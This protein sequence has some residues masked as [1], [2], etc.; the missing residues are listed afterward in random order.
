VSL[1]G[2]ARAA[3]RLARTAASA[4]ILVPGVHP[5]LTQAAPESASYARH[6]ASCHAADLSGSQFGPALKGPTFEAH[7]RNRDAADFS[8]Y[9]ES[10][11]PPAAPGTLGARA[12]AEIETFVLATSGLAVAHGA[13]TEAQA[14]AP[15]VKPGA[16]SRDLQPGERERAPV[17]G[18]DRG[19]GYEAALARRAAALARLTAVSDVT[20]RHP[21][22]GDWLMWRRTYASDGYSP[23]GKIDRSNVHRLR[24]AWSWSLPASQNETTPLVHD[25]VMFVQSGAAVQALDA[26]NG[27]LL[28]QYVRPLPDEL[29]NGHNS[30]VR[31]LAIH[32][33]WLFTATA[34]GHVVALDT[35]SGRP[36][37]DREVIAE[38]QRAMNGQPEGVALHLHGGPIV[39]AG[40]VIVGTSLGVN[41]RGGCF[42]VALDATTGEEAW[43]FYTIARPGEPG[44]D[45]WNGAPL[46]ER[47]GAGTWSPGSY[48][49]ELGLVYFGIGNTYSTATLLEPRP[50]RVLAPNDG[51][52]TDSTVAID[53]ASGKV[54]WHFQHVRRD[55]WDLDWSFEQTI[56]RLPIDG[57]PRK[58]VVSGGKPALFDAVDAATGEYAFA[59]DFGLQ[60]L[61]TAIDP[62]T[63]EKTLNPSVQPE[64]GKPKL[65]CPSP[66]GA[67]NW[68]AT[69]LDPGT[70]ILYVPM[71]E[72]CADYTYTPR[73]AADTAAG[74]ID[75]RFATRLRPDSD[76]NFGRLAALDLEK[77]QVVWTQRQRAPLAGSVLA[78]AGGLVFNGDIDRY[79]SAYDSASGDVLWRTRLG[80]PPHSSPGTFLANARHYVAVVAGAGSCLDASLRALA[81]EIVGPAGGTSVFVF[82]LPD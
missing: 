59:V 27:D 3:S 37:W 73:S 7:W 44:G 9:L 77:R 36:L 21:P 46:D 24:V 68:P 72:V 31:T 2:L 4:V 54:A 67:R 47:Y 78:T 71:S 74:G 25:G 30:R 82:E 53:V 23:L 1:A 56:I 61:V 51:L 62:K 32:G 66:T 70:N 80:A 52:Y 11:M 33:G 41:I 57:E 26:A 35:Q 34:D 55:V 45:S 81:P 75:N 16:A 15:A 60:N 43:R 76:G 13:G 5:G 39:A 58:L 42:I 10:R 40:K 48:D 8:H 17:E 49:P 65:L 28:W 38:A 6:C 50:G 64:A 20:L 18:S 79:F 12:Y 63:G 22:A 14:R 19:P 69:A 29:D